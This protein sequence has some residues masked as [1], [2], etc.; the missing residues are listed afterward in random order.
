MI[1]AGTRGYLD[2]VDVKQIQRW[3]SEFGR[4]MDT[5]YSQLGKQILETGAWNDK[6]EGSVKQAVVEFNN[7]WTN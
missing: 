6:I 2:N 4:F 5:S 7:T 3:K 1:Y